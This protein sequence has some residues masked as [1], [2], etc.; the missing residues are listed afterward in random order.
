LNENEK[1][2][3]LPIKRTNKIHLDKTCP[4]I[5]WVTIFCFV[6]GII[7]YFRSEVESSHLDAHL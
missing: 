7:H 2:K 3:S 1:K 4:L 5:K 6:L